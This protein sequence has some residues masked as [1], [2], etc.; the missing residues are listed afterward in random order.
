MTSNDARDRQL[1]KYPGTD[2]LRNHFGIRD[3]RKLERAEN[4]C[5]QERV[6]QGVPRG[7]FDLDHLKAIHRHLFQDVYPW[8]GEIRRTDISKGSWFHP[9]QRIELGMAD[10][11][12][13]LTQ[14][15]FLKG[16]DRKEFAAQAG[17][18]M[19]DVNH[20]HPFREGNGRAQLQYLKQLG[21]QAG[22]SIDLTRLEPKEW[23]EAS[24]DAS[25]AKYEKM[26]RCI[27]KA[28]TPHHQARSWDR[29]GGD[30]ERG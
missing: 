27:E 20:C 5:F 11:H 7:N 26:A 25:Q 12:K 23:I 9:H 22:H 4:T 13:R 3:P 2:T 21:A 19:G 14:Q 17:Q 30:I 24:I 18:I 29:S 6:R 15:N 16:L 1:Y 28:R 10:V 8:A